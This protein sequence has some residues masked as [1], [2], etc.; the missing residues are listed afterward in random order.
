MQKTNEKHKEDITYLSRS[1]IEVQGDRFCFFL[2]YMIFI[3]IK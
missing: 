2:I 3:E 1:D